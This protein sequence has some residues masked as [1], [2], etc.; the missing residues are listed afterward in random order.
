MDH[1]AQ[2]SCGYLLD[3]VFLDLKVSSTC[4]SVKVVLSQRLVNCSKFAL[5]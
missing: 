2:A 1:V 3:E 4:A 5:S